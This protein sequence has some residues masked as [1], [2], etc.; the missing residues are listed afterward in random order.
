MIGKI[1]ITDQK[2]EL[3]KEYIPPCT[4]VSSFNTLVNIHAGFDKFYGQ[5]ELDLLKILKKINEKDQSNVLARAV[6]HL[7]EN[8]LYFLSTHILEFRWK[9]I[10]QPPLFMF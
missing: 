5:L 3:I 4:T 2:P 9:I 1:R 10:D 7:S 8:L 6:A